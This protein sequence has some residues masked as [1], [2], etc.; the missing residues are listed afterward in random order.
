MRVREGFGDAGEGRLG[1]VGEGKGFGD[2]GE[3]GAWW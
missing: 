3:E 2:A 1:D